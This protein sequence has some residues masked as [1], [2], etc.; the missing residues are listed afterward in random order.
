MKPRLITLIGL[1]VLSQVAGIAIG[2]WFFRLYLTAVPPIAL[3]EF[4]AYSSRAVHL[5]YG[6]G[7]GVVIFL[8]TFVG[9]AAGKL[10]GRISRRTPVPA[11]PAS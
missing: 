2:E 5:L 1:F 3:S 9:M 4:N 8:W 7:V 10:M 6:S 11:A